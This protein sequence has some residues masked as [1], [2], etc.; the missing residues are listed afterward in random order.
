M[1]KQNQNNVVADGKNKKMKKNTAKK[2]PKTTATT[3]EKKKRGAPSQYGNKVKPYLADIE[4]YVRC[5]VT[6]GDICEYYG[7]GKTQWAQY[8]RDNP[9]LTETLLRAKEQCKEDLLDSAYRVAMGYEY[10]EKTTEEIKNLDGTVIG[11]KTRRYKRYAKPDAGMLQ[12][13]LINRYSSEFARDP[14]AIELRKKALELAEQGKMPP[15]GWE[16]V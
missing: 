10:T 14:Q 7:V 3:T 15:D 5:G 8:K 9:E 4:R 1:P 2:K 11:H 12:F 13:L 6:E 16:G